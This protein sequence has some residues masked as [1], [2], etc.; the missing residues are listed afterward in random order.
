M[1]VF[2]VYFSGGRDAM[3]QYLLAHHGVKL[4]ELAGEEIDDAQSALELDEREIV[5]VQPEGSNWCVLLGDI[6]LCFDEEPGA[7][8]SAAS[9]GGEVMMIF[10]QDVTGGAWFE[11]HK[12]GQLRRKWMEVESEV[13]A[14]IGEPLNE[15]DAEHFTDEIDEEEGPPDTWELVELAEAITGIPWDSLSAAGTLYKLPSKD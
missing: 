1:D 2:A 11:Y 7:H 13:E 10:T 3:S 4:D 9:K 15:F 12:G 5:T 8:L 6:S 14:N